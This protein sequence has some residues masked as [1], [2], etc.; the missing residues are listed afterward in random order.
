MSPRNALLIRFSEVFQQLTMTGLVRLFS[1]CSIGRES[2]PASPSSPAASALLQEATQKGQ[3]RV[4]VSLAISSEVPQA[5][6]AIA[7]AQGRLLQDL[8]AYPVEI[9]RQYRTLPLLALEVGS[10]ALRYLLE[11]PL[12]RSVEPDRPLRTMTPLGR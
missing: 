2:E 6:A 10:S 7:Q 12:V 1:A 11:H 3:V 4:I 8:S 5:P 9:V